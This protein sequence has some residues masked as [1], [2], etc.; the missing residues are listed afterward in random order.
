M[1]YQGIKTDRQ[2]KTA[3]GYSMANFKVL[4]SDFE[5]DYLEEYG[6]DYENYIKDNV[7]EPPKLK[8]LEDCLFFTLFQMKNDMMWDSLA[9]VF[10]M[11]GTSAHD[12]FKNTPPC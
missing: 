11:S 7:T 10:G 5:N 8:T 3:T 9:F 2:F 6:E 1:T 4:L 12:N